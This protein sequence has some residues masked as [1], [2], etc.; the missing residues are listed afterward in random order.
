MHCKFGISRAD[1]RPILGCRRFHLAC[2][3]REVSHGTHH[4]AHLRGVP[5]PARIFLEACR[6]FRERLTAC[7]ARDTF[8]SREIA[9]HRRDAIAGEAACPLELVHVGT[10]ERERRGPDEPLL[11]LGVEVV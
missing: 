6:E 7:H 3:V 5:C 9:P 1:G 8:R 4:H 11:G 2:L 10:R